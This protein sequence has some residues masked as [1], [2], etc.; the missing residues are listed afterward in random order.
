LTSA[1]F[2]NLISGFVLLIAV[3]VILGVVARRSSP[4]GVTI[5]GGITLSRT[6]FRFRPGTW[7]VAAMQIWAMYWTCLYRGMDAFVV[8]WRISK[9]ELL[10]EILK[11]EDM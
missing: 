4:S 3:T 5:T 6:R 7:I 10:G 8:E 1:D 9:R 11:C 2:T